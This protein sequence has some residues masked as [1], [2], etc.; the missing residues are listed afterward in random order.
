MSDTQKLPPFYL[1]EFDKKFA[2]TK[3]GKWAFNPEPYDVKYSL[4]TTADWVGQQI[5]DQ[6]TEFILDQKKHEVSVEYVLENIPNLIA[7]IRRS[8]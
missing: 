4:C 8:L 2:I 7:H 3:D 1:T 6:V 5:Q